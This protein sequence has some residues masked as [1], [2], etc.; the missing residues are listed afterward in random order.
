M[1]TAAFSGQDYEGIEEIF[2]RIEKLT[3]MMIEHLY[4]QG[5]WTILCGKRSKCEKLALRILNEWKDI[6]VIH[7]T[8]NELKKCNYDQLVG[9]YPNYESVTDQAVLR[10]IPII[11]LYYML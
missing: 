9:I 7:T 2:P 5:Y 8:T 4:S 3:R 1:K 11:N 6:E 10:K